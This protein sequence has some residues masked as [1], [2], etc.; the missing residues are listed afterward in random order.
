MRD[1]GS[2]GGFAPA[3]LVAIVAI[4]WSL[5]CLGWGREPCGALLDPEQ[6][7][8]NILARAEGSYSLLNRLLSRTGVAEEINSRSSMTVLA[9][10]DATLG[11]LVASYGGGGIPQQQISDT[12]RY[13]VL[14][15][16]MDLPDM[17]ARPPGQLVTTLYQTTG[18]AAGELGWVSLSLLGD[19]RV[20]VGLPFPGAPPNATIVSTVA[21]FPYNI[22]VLQVDR[23][24]IPPQ[25]AQSPP[26]PFPPINITLA[27]L[28]ANRFNTFVAFLQATG[29]DQIFQESEGKEGITIFAPADEAFAA[30]PAASLQ[31]LTA[32]QK[33][34]VLEYHA[35]NTYYALGTLK[36]FKNPAAPTVATSDPRS[37]GAG[38]FTVN[39]TSVD[40][41]FTIYTGVVA[42]PVLDTVLE[43]APVSIFVI[44]K[45]LLPRTLFGP[46]GRPR[47]G[48]ALSPPFSPADSFPS[49]PGGAAEP[50]ITGV[51]PPPPPTNEPYVPSYL[52]P[53][54]PLLLPPATDSPPA[55]M[56][57]APT[58]SLPSS[59]ASP[60]PRSAAFATS[61][62]V[63]TS[64]LLCTWL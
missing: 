38:Q 32:Q 21:L 5:L 34:L 63:V 24:L 26:P 59:I 1:A 17:R 4:F 50:P 64:R 10:D 31:K 61:L 56:S 15:E 60:S 35:L 51:L 54:P 41:V 37:G 49:S 44:E 40:G 23:V 27:L 53:P 46:D 12:L 3:P 29:V 19:G 8:T 11:Q 14:L 36:E 33:I 25:L 52:S 18:R 47:E 48:P 6:N 13:H 28:R 58:P 55:D 22:S 45:V 43:E 9:P 62:F 57:S 39:V 20:G 30:L 16:Y 7:I 42:A 2:A